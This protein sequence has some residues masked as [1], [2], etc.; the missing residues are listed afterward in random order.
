[1]LPNDEQKMALLQTIFSLSVIRAVLVLYTP[2]THVVT[3]PIPIAPN[4]VSSGDGVEKGLDVDCKHAYWFH[5]LNK[6]E[7]Y[8]ER[9]FITTWSVLDDMV[10]H[11][12]CSNH[13]KM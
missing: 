13:Y 1:M 9:S 11:G 6:T 8:D 3:I 5:H 12:G 4:L 10:N 7:D 2:N